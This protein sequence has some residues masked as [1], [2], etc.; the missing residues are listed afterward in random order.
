MEEDRALLEE[1]T[2]I[3]LSMDLRKS[4]AVVRARMA[5]KKLPVGMC[6]V[7]NLNQAEEGPG[8]DASGRESSRQLA[9]TCHSVRALSFNLE[10]LLTRSRQQSL[11]APGLQCQRPLRNISGTHVLR[12]DRLLGFVEVSPF[13]TTEDISDTL[14][15]TVR[16]ACGGD[17]ELWDAV[18]AKVVGESSVVVLFGQSGAACRRAI[19]A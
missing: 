18:R 5:L 4:F 19:S 17:G 15:A 9:N 13:A 8:K 6:A 1:A 11:L 7:E 16:A 14:V 12:A 3:S 2:H 10:P